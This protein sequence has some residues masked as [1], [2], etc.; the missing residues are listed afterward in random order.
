MTRLFPPCATVPPHS[1]SGTHSIPPW[2]L[3]ASVLD[4]LISPYSSRLRAP[5]RPSHIRCPSSSLSTLS[6]TSTLV[7]DPVGWLAVNITGR[8]GLEIGDV[9]EDTEER[10]SASV[11]KGNSKPLLSSSDFISVFLPPNAPATPGPVSTPS[12][13]LFLHPPHVP[14]PPV[15]PQKTSQSDKLRS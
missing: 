7:N 2:S 11:G 15:S 4:I 8:C 9:K 14:G 10:N 3:Q 12:P 13:S 5:R 6:A 1:P